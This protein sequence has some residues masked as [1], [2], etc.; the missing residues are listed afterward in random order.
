V[1]LHPVRVSSRGDATGAGLR[2]RGAASL[3]VVMV[4]FFVLTMV[5]AYTSRNLL[6]EQ[7]ISANQARSTQALEAA[8]AGIEWAVAQ[9]SS[10][11][12]TAACMASIDPADNSF[13]QRY[14][15]I[16]AA[17]LMRRRLQ[18]TSGGALWPGCYFDVGA[19][20]N[21]PARAWVCD[22]PADGPPGLSTPTGTG[23]AYP[24]FRVRF[25]TFPTAAAVPDDP[26]RPGS[27]RIES[28]GC[29][30]LID[31]CLDFGP[32]PVDGEG[33][34]TIS[35]VLAL[36]PVLK[37]PP[38]AA[39]TVGGNVDLGANAVLATNTDAASGGLVL[40]VAGTLDAATRAATEAAAVTIGGVPLERAIVEDDTSLLMP[41]VAVPGVPAADRFFAGFMGLLPDV[42]QDQPLVV[43]H[44]CAPSCDS[45]EVRALAEQHPGRPLWLT[46]DVEFD[47]NVIIETPPQ[48]GIPAQP[49]LVIVQGTVT[50]SGTS[51]LNGVL[52]VRAADWNPTPGFRING[53]LLVE[54][55]LGDPASSTPSATPEVVYDP[56]VLAELRLRQGSFVRVPG[57]WRDFQ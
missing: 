57:S 10:G 28:R 39:V 18:P 47:G 26:L 20:L 6:F 1:S 25:L 12:I 42:Y 35:T 38:T 21:S 5:A 16:D 52:Y 43:R 45:A 34:A 19:A 56:G 31:G 41:A 9:L 4:L 2:Q 14:V 32:T 37:T 44:T 22:C 50:A 40:H 46:G 15:D 29:T 49:V 27:I 7:R 33:Q 8:E 51:T 53:A 13:R 17:G 23:L 55:N 30:Q 54:G 48:P 24:A 36:H 11:R 3:V